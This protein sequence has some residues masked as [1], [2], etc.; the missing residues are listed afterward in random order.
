VPRDP[1]YVGRV[2]V[3]DTDMDEA[4]AL[5]Y[6]KLA[7][8]ASQK[9]DEPE[10]NR[11]ADRL[12]REHADLQETFEWFTTHRRNAE[13]LRLAADLWTFQFDRGYADE[14]RRWLSLALEA[15]EGQNPSA[16]LATAL[17]GAGMFAFRALDQERAQRYFE[18]LLEVGRALGDESSVGRAYGGLSRVALRRGDTREIRRWSQQGLELARRRGSE[19]ETATPLHMFAEAARVDGNLEE[20]RRFYTENLELNRRLG[21][22]H[23]IRAET[24]NLGAIEVLAGNPEAAVPRLRESLRMTRES[25][26]RFL[27]PYVLA[28]TARVALARHD[29][30]LA[31]RLLAAA[32]AQSERTGLAMDPDE[33]PE[34]RKGVA[35]C[36]S[37]LSAAEFQKNWND[38]LRIPD[39]ESLGL[40]E[41]LLMAPGSPP[42]GR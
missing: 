35:A 42:G 23:W 20:A 40:A 39:E 26:D 38:G 27:T 24:L 33:E 17:Y 15:H 16:V 19:A 32:Q 25:T 14:G 4:K 12:E 2:D 34:F 7:D 5:R 6:L 28:W 10:G 11:W 13:A 21:R 9:L 3:A 29:S 1:R 30:A 37:A 22:E 8:E 41:K 36:R 18:E 31:T